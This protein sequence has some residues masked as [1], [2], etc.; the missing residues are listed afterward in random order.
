M[1]EFGVAY[2]SIYSAQDVQERASDS[3]A[4]KSQVVVSHPVEVG[5][6]LRSSAEQ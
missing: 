4:Q 3:R 1:R 2:V 6:E 5:L